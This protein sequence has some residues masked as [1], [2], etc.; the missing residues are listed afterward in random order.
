MPTPDSATVYPQK[1][2][3]GLI[4]LITA[5]LGTIFACIP[6]ALI[7]GWVLLPIA[8]IL[9]IVALCL[10]GRKKTTG[11]VALIVSVVGT[12][13]GF[14]VFFAVV[15]TAID[16]SFSND[17]TATVPEDQQD[18]AETDVDT[19]T[20]DATATEAVAADDAEQGTRANPYPLGT[21]VS[22]GE[23]TITINSVDLNATEAVLA[24]NPFNDEPA[25]DHVY[26]LANVTAEYT[27]TD[28]DGST[29]WLSLSYV[30]PAGNTFDAT[31]A[32]AVAPE[33]FDSATT[34]FEGA[35]ETGNIALQVPAD[36]VGEGVLSF[37]PGFFG[38]PVYVAVQ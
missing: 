8:F 3:V 9:A 24:E 27:G 21:D 35:S 13:I 22:D 33:A 17:V 20:D 10:K 11:I 19:V 37:T 16:D 34:L 28:A 31:D 7:V 4:A 5:V 25:A 6:G 38:N 29:P 26:L 23:W 2:T 36:S 32:L 14:V 12:V 18:Q 1:N 30:S 15:A